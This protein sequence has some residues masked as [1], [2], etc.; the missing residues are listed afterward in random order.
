M[1]NFW[2]LEASEKPIE[3]SNPCGR[4]QVQVHERV[5]ERVQVTPRGSR[6]HVI[7][8]IS[9]GG[10]TRQES[11]TSPAGAQLHCNWRSQMRSRIVQARR[12]A[13]G[14]V[15]LESY[16]MVCAHCGRRAHIMPNGRMCS[17]SLRETMKRAER[18]AYKEG[19][20]YAE[21]GWQCPG[22]HE[23]HGPCAESEED[24]EGEEEDSSEDEIV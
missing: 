10:T 2:Q 8:H 3:E 11:H 17:H 5:H 18:A 14:V 16:S 15:V 9:P 24:E 22:S 12:E 23:Y 13:R 19:Q 6:A 4:T 7:E 1:P 20:A 21:H